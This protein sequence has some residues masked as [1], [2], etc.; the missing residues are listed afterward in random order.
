MATRAVSTV[1]RGTAA[2]SPTDPHKAR[3]ISTATVS[4]V[5]TVPSESWL[6]TNKISSGSAAPA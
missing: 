5:A 2:I 6:V 1:V 3:T 4:L